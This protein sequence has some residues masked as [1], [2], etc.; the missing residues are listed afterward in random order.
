MMR[1]SKRVSAAADGTAWTFL[2]RSESS[3]GSRNDTLLVASEPP[4]Y[5][6]GCKEEDSSPESVGYRLIPKDTMVVGYG[7]LGGGV[8]KVELM[9]MRIL[10]WEDI[11]V[12]AHTED[13]EVSSSEKPT[14]D[15]SAES[16]L[17][18]NGSQ[19][20]FVIG[21]IIGVVA[22]LLF[23]AVPASRRRQ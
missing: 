21:I 1:L 4:V 18:R 3:S 23:S 7:A 2:G 13:V 15:P 5:I 11:K 16:N 19:R 9:K 8:S 22:T 6:K 20:G 14:E 12:G 17:H 10:D